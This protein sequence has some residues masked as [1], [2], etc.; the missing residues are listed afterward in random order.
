MTTAST[1]FTFAR[2]F[3]HVESRTGRRVTNASVIRRIWENQAEY[4]ADVLV[5]LARDQRRPEI[6]Q[7]LRAL[8]SVLEE[9]DLQSVDSR[10][11]ALHELCRV[12]G[13]AS[14]RAIASSPYW[15][16][17]VSMQ[18]IAI[19]SSQSDQRGRMVDAVSESYDS[20][21]DFWEA[22]YLVLTEYLGFRVRAPRTVRQFTIAVTALTDG[23][24]MRHH[25]DG[26][27]HEL[28]LPTGPNHE[29]QEWTI[30][31]CGLAALVDQFLSRIPHFSHPLGSYLPRTQPLVR[32]FVTA[33]RRPSSRMPPVRM[34]QGP[35]ESRET[36]PAA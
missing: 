13:G 35:R 10:C 23:L 11:H 18:V 8:G 29:D 31:S 26:E 5:S 7:T 32:G 4:Q 36:N 2:V 1:N 3:E 24:S 30:F 17:W 6:E 25:I 20:V 28:V 27:I 33:L 16:L 22:N 12:G 9:V 15:S 14:S 19:T 21:T 34:G